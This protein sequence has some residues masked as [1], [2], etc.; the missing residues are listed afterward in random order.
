MRFKHLMTSLGLVVHKE[1]A[2]ASELLRMIC[3]WTL[4]AIYSFELQAGI[5]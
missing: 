3:P 4:A 2:S 1:V 5:S